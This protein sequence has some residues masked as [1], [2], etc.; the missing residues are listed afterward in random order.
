MLIMDRGD[1]AAE[2]DQTAVDFRTLLDNATTAALRAPSNGTRW[3]NEQLLFHMLFG[4]MLTR[5]LLY[6]VHAFARLPDGASRRFATALN[7]ATRPFHRINYAGSLGGARVLGYHRM[8]RTFQRTT[9][10]LEHRLA[11]ESDTALQRGMHF[12][13]G[14][15]PYFQDYLTIW[16]VYHYP[17]QHYRHHRAQLTL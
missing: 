10:A 6:L 8:E 5:N 1:I 2:L 14:W 3:T 15:D 12:P 16:D 9:T 7:A 17:T 13:T 4:Y 11:G